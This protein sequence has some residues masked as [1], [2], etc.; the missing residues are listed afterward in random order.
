MDF[1]NT[2]GTKQERTGKQDRSNPDRYFHVMGQG[3]YVFTRK[4]IIGPYMTKERAAELL[5]DQ[6]KSQ[7]SEQK[8]E[9]WRYNAQ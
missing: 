3:W 6:I 4:E 9:S 1:Q 8:K 2:L 5:S 7:E